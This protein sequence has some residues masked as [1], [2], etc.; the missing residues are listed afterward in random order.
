MYLFRLELVC[1][2]RTKL[3]SVCC[4]LFDFSTFALKDEPYLFHILSLC[5]LLKGAAG[6]KTREI[7][8]ME[9]GERDKRELRDRMGV[10]REEEDV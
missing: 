4:Q 10:G 3:D 7:K 1:V 5:N 6:I 8:L 2:I 9:R